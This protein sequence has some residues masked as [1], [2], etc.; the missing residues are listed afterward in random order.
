[1]GAHRG[2]LARFDAHR[3]L[4]PRRPDLFGDPA[5][6]AGPRLPQK[7]P[8][9]GVPGTLLR[10]LSDPG[11]RETI[12]AI[13]NRVEAFHGFADW[14]AFGAEDGVIAHNDP[15]YQEKLIKFNQLLA[16]CAIYSTAVDI[17][18]TSNTLA[19]EGHPTDPVDLATVTP[20]ITHTV[21]RFG[22]W[23]LDLTPPEAPVVAHLRL[24]TPTP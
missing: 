9:P 1:L 23:H 2:A 20:Y 16:N 14:L 11:L 6:T 24:P 12:T 10:F 18:A 22:D 17:T 15:V 7:P 8:L 13:T 19:A 3:D 21:R 4:H 5:A